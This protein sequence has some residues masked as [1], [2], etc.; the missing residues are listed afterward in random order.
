M[1]ANGYELPDLPNGP[2]VVRCCMHAPGMTVDNEECGIHFSVYFTSEFE[3][4]MRHRFDAYYP[5]NF[6]LWMFWPPKRGNVSF[7]LDDFPQEGLASR[8]DFDKI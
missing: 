4:A 6:Y 2:V 5:Q 1:N 8:W 7:K 3:N